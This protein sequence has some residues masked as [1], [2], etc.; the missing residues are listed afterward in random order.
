MVVHLRFATDIPARPEVVFGHSVSIDA[1]AASMRRWNGRAVAGRTSGHI[2]PGE[3]VT[4]RARHGGII[5]R[6]T[7]RIT[8]YN[9]PVRFVDE[10]V[11]GPFA[12]YRH[13]HRFEPT[14]TG[15]LLLDEITFAAP[16][17]LAGRL[18]ERCFLRRRVQRLIE[19]RNSHIRDRAS[20]GTS[21]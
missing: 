13:V 10:Q 5:W 8:E 6:L 21:N 2:G 7:S 17:G 18:A 1:H 20:A 3:Q 15:T 12:H 16:L 4:W 19:T 14:E 9:R 11:R